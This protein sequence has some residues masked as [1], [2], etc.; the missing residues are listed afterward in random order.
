MGQAQSP[1]SPFNWR[2][3]RSDR[4]SKVA[5]RAEAPPMFPVTPRHT[6][7]EGHWCHKEQL[8]AFELALRDADIE[9]QNLVTV[10]SILPPG[11][12][13]WERT[14]VSPRCIPARSRSL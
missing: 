5:L 9:Q 14:Q 11:C 12:I 8:T 2:R 7:S 1:R 10:S 3:Q 4:V 6:S 13:E